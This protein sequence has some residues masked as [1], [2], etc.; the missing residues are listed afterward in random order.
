MQLTLRELWRTGLHGSSYNG[1]LIRGKVLSSNFVEFGVL[2]S[3]HMMEQHMNLQWVP[4]CSITADNS[5]SLYW[6]CVGQQSCVW[7][8]SDGNVVADC[9]FSISYEELGTMYWDCKGTEATSV[10]N[11]L[12]RNWSNAPIDL[13]LQLFVTGRFYTPYLC[14]ASR[15]S[16]VP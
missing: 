1:F 15:N 7:L 8:P 3:R 9:K 12:L 5:T 6:T 16:T 4:L 14:S 10:F 2:Y 13:F 11:F